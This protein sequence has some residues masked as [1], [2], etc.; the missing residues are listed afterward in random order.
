M[1]VVLSPEHVHVALRFPCGYCRAN[2]AVSDPRFEKPTF[3]G[4]FSFFYFLKK[5]G[6]E[7]ILKMDVALGRGRGA[8]RAVWRLEVKG[9]AGQI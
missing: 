1:F 4:F 7:G 3:D 8:R 5:K 6:D 9:W 2:E